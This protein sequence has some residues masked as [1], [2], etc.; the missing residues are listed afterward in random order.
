[1]QD[2]HHVDERRDVDLVQLRSLVRLAKRTRHGSLRCAW[3]REVSLASVEVSRDQAQDLSGGVTRHDAI[4]TNGAC[5]MI[6]DDD[7]WNCG[8]E[9]DGGCQQRL[10]D[11]WGDDGKVGGLRLGDANEA[12]HDAPDGAEQAD[13]GR[14]CTN[15]RQK[16]RA[17]V[18]VTS[19]S[20]LKAS[21]PTGDAFLDADFV[22]DIG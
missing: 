11:T 16:S 1:E 6:V 19:G 21:E 22:S 13:K 18:H 5:K 20:D 9:A 12:V 14:R 2:Q 3:H 10:G 15:R 8:K 4:S 17:P 7:R